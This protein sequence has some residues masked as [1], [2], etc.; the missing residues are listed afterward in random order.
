MNIRL[1]I[2]LNCT[3]DIIGGIHTKRA[4]LLGTNPKGEITL[5]GA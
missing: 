4:Q 3:D 1:T 2:T 5:V